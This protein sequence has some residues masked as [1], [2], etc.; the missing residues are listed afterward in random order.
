VVVKQMKD[1]QPCWIGK[2]AK[3][4]FCCV[5]ARGHLI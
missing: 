4:Q 5:P 3:F 1:S 2:G